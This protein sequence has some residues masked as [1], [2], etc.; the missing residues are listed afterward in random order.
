MNA[1]VLQIPGVWRGDCP[2]PAAALASTRIEALDRALLGGWPVGAL[3]QIVGTE[4]GLGFSLII[5]ALAACTAAGRAVAL[6]DPPYLPYAPAL[7]SRGVDLEHLLWIRPQDAA[8]AQWAAEQIAHSGLFAALACWGALD[9]TA[10]R[11]LQLA[12][13]A[14]QCLVFCFRTGRA[15]GHSHAAV[16]LAV[17]PAADAQLRVEVLKCRGGRA[18]HGLL[19]RCV[20]LPVAA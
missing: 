18:G 6:I 7:A 4:A 9:G 19:H 10:E 20:D 5:P 3:T 16:R 15:D 2:R 1:P 8:Q 11:R 12:A 14:A 17:A 13:D